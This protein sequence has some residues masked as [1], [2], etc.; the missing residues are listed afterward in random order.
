MS[1]EILCLSLEFEPFSC[2]IDS[3]EPTQYLTTLKGSINLSNDIDDGIHAGSFKITLV[4]CDGAQKDGYSFYDLFDATAEVESFSSLFYLKRKRYIRAIEDLINDGHKLPLYNLLIIDSIAINHEYI[5]R[6]LGSKVIRTLTH[7]FR[8]GVSIV[9]LK[10]F[11]LQFEGSQED[12][13]S[14]SYHFVLNE[15]DSTNKIIHQYQKQGFVLLSDLINETRLRQFGN[16]M[17]SSPCMIA[18]SN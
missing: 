11:P 3:G 8:H 16:I 7:K 6:G 2:F 9:A 12:D 13:P 15:A 14:Y 5:G 10:P 4:D 18:N 1:D 17:V